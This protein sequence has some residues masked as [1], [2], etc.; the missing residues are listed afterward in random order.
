[1]KLPQTLR[2]D[3]FRRPKLALAAS[4]IVA[5]GVW[6]AGTETGERVSA[7]IGIKDSVAQTTQAAGR[8]AQ[9]TSEALDSFMGRSPGERGATDVLKGK[10][11]RLAA[12]KAKARVRGVPSVSP[13]QRAL[14]KIFDK[15]IGGVADGL[16]P[17]PDVTALPN[18][19]LA[20]S[21]PIPG[22]APTAIVGPGA[23]F[24]P[25]FGGSS[26]GAFAGGVGGGGGGGGGGVSGG[27]GGGTA[28]PP[29][30]PGIISAVPEPST[31]MMLLFGFGA[32]GAALRSAKAQ[33]RRVGHCAIS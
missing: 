17:R 8:V 15:P 18:E 26:G 21:G 2:S 19:V 16:T 4:L 5:I 25:T 7:Q 14:G 6:F 23:G 1:M 13:T 12:N 27:I 29:V 33:S 28:V 31:W 24:V 22:L 30:A 11:K 10:T 9:Q 32:I 3:K 20:F